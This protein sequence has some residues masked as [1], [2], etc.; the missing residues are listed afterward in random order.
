M[1]QKKIS[2]LLIMSKLQIYDVVKNKKQ[3]IKK[4]YV[5]Q[6][7]RLR[8]RRTISVAFSEVT[9]SQLTFTCSKSTIETPE[10]GMKYVQSH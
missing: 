4:Q 10:K 5:N 9:L 3:N 7:H 8:K 2:L 1:H 6:S